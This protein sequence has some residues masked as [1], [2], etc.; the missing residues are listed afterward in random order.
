[1]YALYVRLTRQFGRGVYGKKKISNDY[2][3]EYKGQL[4]IYSE[5]IKKEAEYELQKQ[6]CFLYFL[7]YNKKSYCIDAMA[8]PQEPY[9]DFGRLINRSIKCANIKSRVISDQHGTPHIVFIAIRDIPEQ[10]FFNYGERRKD[11]VQS[12]LWIKKIVGKIFHRR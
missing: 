11:V 9:S 8:E 1:M 5:A 4:L 12:N 2:I 7:M 6:G 10:L 3:C